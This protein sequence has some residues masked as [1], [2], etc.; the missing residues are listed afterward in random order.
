MNYDDLKLQ[1][2][3]MCAWCKMKEALEKWAYLGY[4]FCSVE[5]KREWYVKAPD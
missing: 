5:C 1:P 2:G 4:H 3:E